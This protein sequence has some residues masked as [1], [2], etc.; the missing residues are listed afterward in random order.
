MEVLE[1]EMKTIKEYLRGRYQEADEQANENCSWGQ[2]PFKKEREWKW[3]Q[4]EKT[5]KAVAYKIL[6]F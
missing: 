4:K 2:L 6:S 5:N 3:K 1:K